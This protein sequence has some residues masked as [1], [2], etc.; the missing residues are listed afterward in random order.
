MV[1]G[2]PAQRRGEAE[3]S[4]QMPVPKGMEAGERVQHEPTADYSSQSYGRVARPD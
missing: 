3:D 4:A 1:R 2:D